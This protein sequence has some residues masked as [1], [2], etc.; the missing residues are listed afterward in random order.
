MIADILY[1]LALSA[2]ASTAAIALILILRKPL[3]QRF[4]AQAAYALWAL[5][6]LSAAMVL[7]PAPVATVV[8]P[9]TLAPMAPAVTHAAPLAVAVAATFDPV[10]WLGA[11]WL[12]GLV[13]CAALFIRQQRSFVRALG[14]LS[15]RDD[16]TSQAQTTAGCPALIGAWRP[17]IVLP[18]DFERRYDSAERDL[19]LAHERAHRAR[20]D[21][22]AN[23]LA[24]TLRCLYWFNPLLH[25]AAS[26][27]RFDQE[28]A[29]DA[30]VI[31]RFPEARRPYADAMLKT[32]LADLGLPAGCHWQSSHPLKERIAM[33]KNPLPGRARTALG[34][35]LVAALVMGG[36]YAT[37]AA[38]PA[39]PPVTDANASAAQRIHTGVLLSDVVL[40]IDGASLDASWALTMTGDLARYDH[41]KGPSSLELGLV[42]GHPF[43]IEAHR[44]NESWRIDGTVHPQTDD[45]FEIESTLTHNGSVVSQPKLITRSGEPAGIKI[46]EEKDGKF[47]GF[48]A[49]F[50]LRAGG[51]AAALPPPD[52]GSAP[53][54]NASYRSITRIEYP[55]S[56]IDSNG[57]G[58]VYIGV[59]IGAD[60]KVADAKVNSVMP[61]VR[62][63]LADAALAAVKTWT[64]E[65]R[66]VDGKAVASD[67]IV[68]IAF[69]LDPKKPLTVQPGVLDAIRVSPPAADF[70]S[71]EDKSVTENVEFRLMHSPKYPAVAIKAHEQGKIVLK[72]HVDARG[73]PLEANVFKAE[74]ENVAATFGNPS[75]AAVMQWQFNPARKHGKAIDGWVLVPFTFSLTEM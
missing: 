43:S 69:S 24:A 60:G 29:C 75:I 61:M 65:P 52:T 7:L 63:D 51:E 17:R 62:T 20:G 15:P 74:P 34:L 22:Q 49:Q 16:G 48:G 42:V 39:Q 47:K 26:R 30:T 53:T 8:T 70:A 73:L 1:R 41:Q 13:V 46:G 18:V 9:M 35:G 72:V 44:G 33:L 40:S 23:A 19:I 57:Q 4:G 6:P 27:F 64:F 66:K 71:S 31:A 45:K 10:P 5:V 21:A 38:Q 14:N 11:A 2:F 54:E 55:Q 12:L 25:F 67:T 37:W 36:S 28:L 32:Q 59:H 56:A 68:S 50:V 58:V 3:R